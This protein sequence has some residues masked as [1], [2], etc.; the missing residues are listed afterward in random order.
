M[1]STRQLPVSKREWSLRTPSWPQYQ[2]CPSAAS[3]NLVTGVNCQRSASVNSPTPRRSI[4]RSRQ[5]SLLGLSSDRPI[6][7]SVR[8][9]SARSRATS[10]I[11]SAS[12][13]DPICSATSR[14]GFEELLERT[15]K[16]SSSN[17]GEAETPSIWGEDNNP[18]GCCGVEGPGSQSQPAQDHSWSLRQRERPV[19]GLGSILQHHHSTPGIASGL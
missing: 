1:R 18:S 13:A 19:L 12:L 9:K 2:N 10:K 4:S 8:V 16:Y 15:I 6:G 11:P 17:R 7:Q 5:R 3:R 14:A